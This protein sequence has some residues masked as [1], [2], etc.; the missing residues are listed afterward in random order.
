MGSRNLDIRTYVILDIS[1]V[2]SVNFSQVLEDSADTVRH[3]LDNTKALVK[4]EGDTPSFL[5]GKT[6]YNHSQ[7]STILKDPLDIWHISDF[8]DYLDNL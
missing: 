7:I 3:S 4:F 1:E 2:S 5:E 6:E 8:Q